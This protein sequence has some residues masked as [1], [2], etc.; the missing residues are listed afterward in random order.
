MF[1]DLLNKPTSIDSNRVIREEHNTNNINFGGDGAIESQLSQMFGVW[2]ASEYGITREQ[3]MARVQAASTPE[4]REQV[5]AE[6]KARA[7]R[8]AGLDISTGRVA[9][10]SANTVPWHGL[11]VV[12]ENVATTAEA[13]QASGLA[14]WN[15]QKLPSSILVNGDWIKTGGYAVVR[16]DTATVLGTV[17][18]GYT[19]FSNEE[20]FSFMDDVLREDA[21]WETAGALGQGEQ[22]WCLARM[23]QVDRIGGVDTLER[24]LLFETAHDGTG[25]NRCY[26]TSVRVECANTKRIASKDRG[27][28]LAFRHTKNQ[29]R[30]A[31][32]VK[33]L[34]G[35]ANESFD[36][37]V[38]Q[39]DYL[40]SIKVD[41]ATVRNYF[42]RTIDETSRSTVNG[43]V[44]RSETVPAIVDS[45][46][47]LRS[48]NRMVEEK[49]LERAIKGQQS[50][51]ME[52]IQKHDGTNNRTARGSLW[53]CYS[54]V[55]EYADHSDSR[56]YRGTDREREERRF[57]STIHG[58]ADELKSAAF[59]IALRN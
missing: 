18:S 21:K 34:L 55:S 2:D 11:G 28:G 12:L 51:F 20:I 32:K 9:M 27:N 37:F 56:R 50:L 25:A 59:E 22:V 29:K 54:A 41:D 36:S 10:F 14:G 17:G 7:L 33:R 31:E 6:L 43:I 58:A 19:V 53:G 45:L 44:V 16:Q 42:R 52:L 47:D 26:P 49:R 38:E 24:Y 15:L 39:A 23:P 48:D 30:N 5:I 8:R 3:A 46:K 40:S 1:T 13:L 4:A 57:V 35:L